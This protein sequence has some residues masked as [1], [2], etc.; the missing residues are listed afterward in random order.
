MASACLTP[1]SVILHLHHHILHPAGHLF[2]F[3]LVGFEYPLHFLLQL[4]VH[5]LDGLQQ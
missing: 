3:I 5:G 4:P 1:Q 2:E